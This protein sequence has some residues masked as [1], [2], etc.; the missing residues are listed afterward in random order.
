M[1]MTRFLFTIS[2]ASS[3]MQEFPLEDRRRRCRSRVDDICNGSS[4]SWLSLLRGRTLDFVL[5]LLSRLTKSCDPQSLSGEL[6][7]SCRGVLFRRRL[8]LRLAIGGIVLNQIV[9]NG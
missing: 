9:L 4:F 5:W 6:E 7:R 3:V 2:F 1:K 8:L